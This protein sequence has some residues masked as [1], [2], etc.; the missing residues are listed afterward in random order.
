[1]SY[2]FDNNPDLFV[3][4][5][6][7]LIS[8]AVYQFSPTLQATSRSRTSSKTHSAPL[9]NTLF[10]DYLPFHFFCRFSN[11]KALSSIFDTDL[12]PWVDGQSALSSVFLPHLD[13]TEQK[14]EFGETQPVGTETLIQVTLLHY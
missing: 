4:R 1:M 12:W 5:G 6:K 3:A 8:P 13:S 14:F 2:I 9:E 10:K 7:D 11:E